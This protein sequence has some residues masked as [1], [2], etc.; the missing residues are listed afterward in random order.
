MFAWLMIKLHD[1]MILDDAFMHKLFVSIPGRSCVYINTVV[2]SDAP[3]WA[4]WTV[5]GRDYHS[6]DAD[7]CVLGQQISILF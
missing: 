1:F 2:I 4:A 3:L 6:K 5:G 7:L